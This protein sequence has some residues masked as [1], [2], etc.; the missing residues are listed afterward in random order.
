MVGLY[1]GGLLLTAREQ[2][3]IGPAEEVFLVFGVCVPYSELL[4]L[5]SCHLIWG[6]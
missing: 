3:Q 5:C 4:D 1:G 6:I 2:V